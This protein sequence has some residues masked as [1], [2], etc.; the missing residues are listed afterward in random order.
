MSCVQAIKGGVEDPLVYLEKISPEASRYGICKIVSPLNASIPAGAVLAKENTGFKF[1]TRV[2]PLWL[3]DWNVDDKVIFFMRGRNYTLHDFENMANKEFSSKYCCSGSLPSMYLEKEFWHEIASGRKGT[4]EYAINIDGSAFSCASNDQLG[5]SKWNLKVLNLNSVI[6]FVFL[7]VSTLPQLPKSPLRLCETSIP[8]VTDPMLYIGMLF[9]MFAWHVEDHYLYSINYHHCGAP[10]TWYGVPEKTTMFAPCTLL[11]HD[12]PVYKAV[13]MPG[14]FVI[15][16]PKAYHAGFTCGE[17]VN[18]AVGDWF[19]FGA[20]ASQRYS[21]L[22]RMP[23]IPYEELL[24]K[25]AM[26]LHNSQEQGGLAHSSADLASYHCVK[27]SFICLIQSHHHACQFLKKIKG[28]P[29]VSPNSQGTILCSLCKRDC[30]VAYINCNCYS[31]PICLFHEIEALNC[32]C[33][34]NPILFLREDV[35]KMEKIAKKFEQDKGIMR[36]VH[37]YKDDKCLQKNETTLKVSKQ[38]ELKPGYKFRRQGI[39]GTRNPRRKNDVEERVG[40]TAETRTECHKLRG[41]PFSRGR[42]RRKMKSRQQKSKKSSSRL[43][44]EEKERK[45]YIVKHPNRK[46]KNN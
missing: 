37:R 16:F 23:I 8:G 42:K 11:Q 32:P 45:P 46:P 31:R 22:C 26:L 14:E 6:L 12:V 7:A 4:V 34:N 15:T 35:S 41:T 1:T 25:E 33:G 9:S 27:V 3:P 18:F 17:A 2:Q 21:R 30:Y 20:E 40:E 28:S 44:T 24:C 38:Q 5:K 10:K 36:E 43:K 13:Q 39:A 19:P 29:S